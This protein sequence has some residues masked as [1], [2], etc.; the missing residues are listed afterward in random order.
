MK[1][2]SFPAWRNHGFVSSR[3][4]I[5][6]MCN[7]YWVS[8]WFDVGYIYVSTYLKTFLIKHSLL[9][10]QIVGDNNKMQLGLQTPRQKGQN[11]ADSSTASP[12][13]KPALMCIT[14]YHHSSQPW[15]EIALNMISQGMIWITWPLWLWHMV[16]IIL[17]SRV[18]NHERW[19]S[20][21]W[22]VLCF[23]RTR[24]SVIFDEMVSVVGPWRELLKSAHAYDSMYPF[25][26]NYFV[27]N[28][29]VVHPFCRLPKVWAVAKS[30][31]L[32]TDNHEQDKRYLWT[33]M[34]GMWVICLI[35]WGLQLCRKLRDMVANSIYMFRYSTKWRTRIGLAWIF[36]II[37]G[38]HEMYL[39]IDCKEWIIA[40]PN[41][42][43]DGM[44]WVEWSILLAQPHWNWY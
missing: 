43:F 6:R 16:R 14:V 41:K 31:K 23:L 17:V 19:K 4:V 11:L 28:L 1:R 42:R 38:F 34:D 18:L 36:L 15:Y 10:V 29:R 32:W 30:R 24:S 2:K 20:I 40:I 8:F 7:K 39:C 27:T 37:V 33:C 12:P 26:P 5:F 25:L 44:N 13:E 3:L 35:V 22:Q 9:N 21:A